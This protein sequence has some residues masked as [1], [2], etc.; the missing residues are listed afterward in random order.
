M[1]NLF[2]I[3]F[4]IVMVVTVFIGIGTSLANAFCKKPEDVL[5][6]GVVLGLLLLFLVA[7]LFYVGCSR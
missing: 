4:A 7:G 6:A 3:I 1:G 5:A 2:G